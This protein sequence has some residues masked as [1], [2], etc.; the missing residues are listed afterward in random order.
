M[1]LGMQVILRL[2]VFC[3]PTFDN[4]S[5]LIFTFKGNIS[6]NVEHLGNLFKHTKWLLEPEK[7]IESEWSRM[8]SELKGISWDVNEIRN[9][10][11]QALEERKKN[12]PIP[13]T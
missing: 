8:L 5:Y 12:K 1:R 7:R 6:S 11:D 10:V 2:K 9:Q 3:C 13:K 4:A